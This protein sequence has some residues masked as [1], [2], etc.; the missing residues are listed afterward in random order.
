MSAEVS[1]LTLHDL[2]EWSHKKRA[3]VTNI[4]PSG[5][6]DQATRF[7]SAVPDHQSHFPS[8]VSDQSRD[9]VDNNLLLQDAEQHLLPVALLDLN[10]LMTE[11][12]CYRC[13][14]CGR[15]IREKVD[16][17][18]HYMIHT[19]ERPYCCNYC[20]YKATRKFTLI[21]HVKSIHPEVCGPP[22]FAAENDVDMQ[23][24]V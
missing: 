8:A 6:C 3:I 16:F 1:P 17:I 22:T 4:P 2:A 14:G 20:S 12:R 9:D 19:G 13:P 23:P 10:Q 7:P 11:N 24:H 15:E 18:R 21:R 5:T